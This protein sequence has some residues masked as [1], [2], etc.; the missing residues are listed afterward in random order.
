MMLWSKQEF[1]V[2]IQVTSS[3]AVV[4]G[5]A[6]ALVMWWATRVILAMCGVDNQVADA[7]LLEGGI[8]HPRS[9]CLQLVSCRQ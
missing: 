7:Q 8:L 4:L 6:F 3:S 2:A 9:V 1:A 5:T